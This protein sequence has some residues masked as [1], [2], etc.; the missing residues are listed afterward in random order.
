MAIAFHGFNAALDVGGK[1]RRH[2]WE[3]VDG[4]DE[5][6]FLVADLDRAACAFQRGAL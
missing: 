5:D 6:A 4:A 1:L 2:R 3:M